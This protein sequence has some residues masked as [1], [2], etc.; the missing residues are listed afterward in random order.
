MSAHTS[1]KERNFFNLF[2]IVDKA[3]RV[4]LG[5]PALI[6]LLVLIVKFKKKKN[7]NLII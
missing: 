4:V 6:P 3:N 5:P 1:P 2:L 7:L